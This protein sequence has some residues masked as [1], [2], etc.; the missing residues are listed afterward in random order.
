MIRPHKLA[1]DEIADAPRGKTERHERG[2]EIEHLHPFET[3]FAGKQPAC[4]QHAEK[5]AVERHAAVPHLDNVRRMGEVVFRLVKQHKAEPPAEYHAE[6]APG[7]EVVEHFHGKRRAALF[8][9]VSAEPHK[10]HEADD[11]AERVPADGERPQLQGNRVE[12]RVDNH[13]LLCS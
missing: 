10:Q 6:H 7:E 8:D 2:D 11:V 1:V 13:V 9:A 3:V 4:R 12:L 5:A